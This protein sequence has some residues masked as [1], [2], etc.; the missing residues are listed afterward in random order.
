[1]ITNLIPTKWYYPS[2][3]SSPVPCEWQ[4]WYNGEIITISLMSVD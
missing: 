1:M 3:S 2:A 4:G